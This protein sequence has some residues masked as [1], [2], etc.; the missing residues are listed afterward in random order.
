VRRT[1]ILTHQANAA[2]DSPH[3][4][5][6]PIVVPANLGTD[7]GCVK[8]STADRFGFSA[9]LNA[10]SETAASRQDAN[11]AL[12]AARV[13][14]NDSEAARLRIVELRLQSLPEEQTI[15]PT[16]REI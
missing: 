11:P 9:T 6:A 15:V 12:V 5:S 13:F 2:P 16:R 8:R 4:T 3:L 14:T 1:L 7:L 10:L